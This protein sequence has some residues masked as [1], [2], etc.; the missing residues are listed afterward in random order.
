MMMTANLVGFVVGLEGVERM[1]QIIIRKEEAVFLV[2]T[3][4]SLYIAVLLMF[5]I[6]AREGKQA[7]RY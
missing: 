2:G 7:L 6:R 5:E 3:F 4:V 1:I